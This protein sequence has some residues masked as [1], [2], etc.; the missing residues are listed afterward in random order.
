MTKREIKKQQTEAVIEMLQNKFGAKNF[1]NDQGSYFTFEIGEFEG[2]LMRRDFEVMFND[3][4]KMGP[5]FTDEEYAV[6][7]AALVLE[8]V[9][10]KEIN[11]VLD[12]PGFEG[13]TKALN[14]LS[15]FKK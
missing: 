6:R 11:N 3:T 2:Q 5:G 7:D 15:I 13:T 1:D 14:N 4:I 9:V 8:E 12:M 10:N